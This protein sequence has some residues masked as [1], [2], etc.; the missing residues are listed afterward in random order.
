M[1]ELAHP[2]GS[3]IFVRHTLDP[4]RKKAIVFGPFLF[5]NTESLQACEGTHGPLNLLRSLN[6]H[7]IRAQQV[8]LSW[9]IEHT[10]KG[11]VPANTDCLVL[12]DMLIPLT[13]EGALV[14]DTRINSQ[15][16][17]EDDEEKMTPWTSRSELWGKVAMR[18]F[19]ASLI[20]QMVN[21]GRPH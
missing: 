5:F 6:G 18:V 15:A 11:F 1:W 2:D 16:E 17:I 8:G 19:N 20:E 3:S 14:A 12:G 9:V 4:K 21:P 7:D 13:H 10:R